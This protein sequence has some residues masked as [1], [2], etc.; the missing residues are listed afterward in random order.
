[1]DREL[2][3]YLDRRFTQFKDELRTELRADI[4]ASAEETR[5]YVDASAEE[6]RRYV[7]GT[8]AETRRHFDVMGER[9]MDKIQL[10]GEGVL[11]I[12]R[13]VDRLA[14]EMRG[15]FQKV[16]RRFLHLHAQLLRPR[17]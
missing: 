5:R 9:L 13:K 15:E 10:V 1:M 7:D 8:A 17:A 4:A 3:E 12:D 6:T 2:I 16:D 11:G 14:T